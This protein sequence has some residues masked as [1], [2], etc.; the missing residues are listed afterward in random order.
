V[1]PLLQESGRD[2]GTAF[3]GTTVIALAMAIVAALIVRHR[4]EVKEESL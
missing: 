4:S 2:L 3:A 1:G